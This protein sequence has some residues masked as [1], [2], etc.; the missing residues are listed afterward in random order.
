[1]PA[2][3]M[4]LPFA[5]S[6]ASE[7]TL[8]AVLQSYSQYIESH[9]SV[10]PIGLAESLYCRRDDFSHKLIL[11]ASSVEDLKAEIDAELE[12]RKDKNPSTIIYRPGAGQKRILGVFTG[13]GAQWPRMGHDL[14]SI[15]PTVKVFEDLQASLDELPAQYRPQYSLMEEF[16]TSKECSRLHQ[17]AIS[18]PI[19]TALQVIQVILLRALG[20][21]F[22]AVVG[23]SSG[24]IAAAYAAGFLTATDAIR[25]SHLRGMFA[26]LAGANSQPGAML[27]AGLSMDEAKAF[28][29]QKQFSERVAVAAS[30]SP[31]SVT[32]SGDVDA[33]KEVEIILKAQGEFARLLN[34]DTAYHSHHMSPC[35]G[36][37]IQA[38]KAIRIQPEDEQ[39]AM[40]YS[41][42]YPGEEMNSSHMAALKDVYWNDN[43]LNTVLFRQSLDSGDHERNF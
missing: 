43:M 27:A 6:A 26:K 11:Y 38:L 15:S 35:S 22:S 8:G 13:Q 31:K 39:F 9:P 10:D 32:L 17:A 1:M 34:V 4:P 40:W 33:V 23:H 37:Y 21:T 7:R 25:I 24:E 19:C 36:A 3:I 29:A 16:S 30:N 2:L 41:S 5:F 42:V 20:I 28:C 12:R 14:I 18:Q